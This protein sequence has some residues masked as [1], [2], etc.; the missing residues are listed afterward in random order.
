[1]ND[2]IAAKLMEIRDREGL[3]TAAMARRIGV[4]SSYLH[5]V[6]HGERNIGRKLLDGA[7]LAWP[8]VRDAH[9]QALT[10][11]RDREARSQEIGAAS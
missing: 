4:D 7:M 11:R 9:A 8:E 5:L 10:I 6:F 2:P 1:M 3:T